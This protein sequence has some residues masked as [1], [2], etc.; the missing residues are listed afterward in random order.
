MEKNRV[1]EIQTSS[2]VKAI[3][4][5]FSNDPNKI[6]TNQTQTAG[7]DMPL[8]Y[9]ANELKLD[10]P[11]RVVSL[12]SHRLLVCSEK[13]EFTIIQLKFDQAD[14]DVAEAYFQKLEIEGDEKIVA[15]SIT[16]VSNQK[17]EKEAGN[18]SFPWQSDHQA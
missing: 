12:S 6:L 15:S 10:G 2:A 3:A 18:Q 8:D 13:G 16:Y 11:C 4:D 7:R 1:T 9:T 17:K 14:I 5:H